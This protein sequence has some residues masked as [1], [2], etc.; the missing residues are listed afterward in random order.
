MIGHT[1]F[2]LPHSRSGDKFATQLRDEFNRR[3]LTKMWSHLDQ[4]RKILALATG[5]ATN[6]RKSYRN[7]IVECQT[8]IHSGTAR[9]LA[10]P[11]N[12]TLP[13]ACHLD[14]DHSY[15]ST[16]GELTDVK[17]EEDCLDIGIWA[18]DE[19]QKLS[20]IHTYQLRS[21]D[22]MEAFLRAKAKDISGAIQSSS[23][24]SWLTEKE[25]S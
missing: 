10:N 17:T 13:V 1:V 11:R 15:S 8:P 14:D 24:L 4:G 19:Y 5:G 7:T 3:S 2:T 20:G 12:L 23:L 9:L 21:R 16:V 25:K 6:I 18:A 22:Q